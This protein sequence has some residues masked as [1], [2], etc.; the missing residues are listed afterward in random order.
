MGESLFAA[1]GATSDHVTTETNQTGQLD[2]IIRISPEDD[3]VGLILQ[4]FVQKGDQPQGVPVYGKFRDGNDDPL[5]TNSRLA[6]AYQAPTDESWTIVSKPFGNIKTY[7]TKSIGDQ[8]DTENIDQVKHKLHGDVSQTLEVR[9]VDEA[10]VLLE[11]STQL[12]HANSEVYIDQDAVEE[13][14]SE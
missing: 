14:D 1:E 4:N 13:V 9:D 7:N 2:P 3:G 11:S 10:F 8:Q 5:P 6:I 12:D